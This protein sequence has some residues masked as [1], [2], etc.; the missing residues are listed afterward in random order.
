MGTLWQDV[1]HGFRMLAH[2]PG[3]TG[4]AIRV[5]CTGDRTPNATDRVWEPDACVA[6]TVSGS[7]MGA[8]KSGH[9]IRA[10]HA[11]PLQAMRAPPGT[12]LAENRTW[13]YHENLR[14]A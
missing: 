13:I 8:P 4:M 14:N 1:R 9:S 6:P 10:R 7:E 5:G 12:P 2:S 11:S 3:F